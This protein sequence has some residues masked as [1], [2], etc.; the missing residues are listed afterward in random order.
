MKN[1]F[2]ELTDEILKEEKII[3]EISSLMKQQ[4]G[5]NNLSEKKLISDQIRNLRIALKNSAD[6]VLDA[7]NKISLYKPLADQ[8]E[9]DYEK[10]NQNNPEIPRISF[11]R[12]IPII[13]DNKKYSK[14]ELSNLESGV[15]KRL[16][17]EKGVRIERRKEKKP[18]L[19]IKA[20]NKIFLKTGRKI[21]E[22]ESF[23]TLKRDLVKANFQIIPASYIAVIFLTVVLSFFASIFIFLLVLIFRVEGGLTGITLIQGGLGARAIKISWIPIVIPL[24][25]F[26]FMYFYPSLEKKSAEVKINRELPFATIHMSSISGSMIDPTKIFEIIIVTKEY[27]NI[28][29][30]FTKLMNEINVYGYDVV[31]SLRKVAFNSP[32]SKFSDLLNGLATTITS[33]GDLPDFFDKRAQTLLFEHKIEREKATKSAETFMDIYIS[34]VIAAPMILMLL[35]M[36]M[37]ISGLGISLSTTS[38]SLI[39]IL[40]VS[41]MNVIFLSFL[42]LKQ[43][44]E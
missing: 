4:E 30:E 13:P 39:V 9:F 12:R 14:M 43:T 41:I 7:V 2:E 32:S 18:S 21:E 24:V 6:I 8:V 11:G 29:K 23:R 40:G 19:Y 25:T 33:G 15:L 20:A 16:K 3:S 28:S 34:V 26:L 44:G 42:Y 1:P 10:N 37:K 38:I 35:L 36:M 22:E 27:P 17:K 31:S 5:A